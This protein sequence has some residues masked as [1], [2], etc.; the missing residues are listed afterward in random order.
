M[1][2]ID[3]GRTPPAGGLH[4]LSIT[5]YAATDLLE[6]IAEVWAEFVTKNA[7]AGATVAEQKIL[8]PLRLPRAGRGARRDS[9]ASRRRAGPLTDA[10]SAERGEQFVQLAERLVCRFRGATTVCFERFLRGEQFAHHQQ[11]AAVVL[12]ER[13]RGDGRIVRALLVR[14]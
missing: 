10:F 11:G 7:P 9:A 6:D 1:P 8:F 13:H 14:P 12:L 3:V 2:H 4:R 5:R